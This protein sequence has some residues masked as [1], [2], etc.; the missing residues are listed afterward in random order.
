MPLLFDIRRC[1]RLDSTNSDLKR[2]FADNPDLPSGRIVVAREQTA[3]RGRLDRKWIASPGKNLCFS[4]FLRTDAPPLRI[5]SLSMAAA[6]AVDDLLHEKGIPST[7]KWPNDVLVDGRKICGILSER[8]ERRSP[9]RTGVVLG[10]GLNVDMTPEEAS[11]IDRPATSMRIERNRI[12]EP[13]AVLNDL[14]PHLARQVETW[15]VAGFEGLR[16]AWTL[17][18]GPIGRPLTVRDGSRKK[19]GR[20]AGFGPY[21]E[22]L[23]ETDGGIEAIWS[24]DVEN[25]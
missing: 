4:L 8:V 24:G 12:F 25:T 3:G 21:G 22:L 6:L 14:L 16:S 13:D 18:A 7:P 19:T 15:D 23:L 20:I 11:A 5:P 10:I 9:D 2:R 17:R 1:N